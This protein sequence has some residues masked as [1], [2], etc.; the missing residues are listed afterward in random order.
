MKVRLLQPAVGP[1]GS[2]GV[3]DVVD[4]PD[5]VARSW[6]ADGAAEA[7]NPAP[8]APEAAAMEAPETATQPV[9]RKRRAK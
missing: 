4:I 9:A 5:S 7:A 6:I 8:V 1:L 3:G 2:F